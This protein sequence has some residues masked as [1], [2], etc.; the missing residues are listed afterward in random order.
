MK[1]KVIE[2]VNEIAIVREVVKV[3]VTVI[4]YEDCIDTAI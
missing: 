2:T 1:L 4:D 3:T